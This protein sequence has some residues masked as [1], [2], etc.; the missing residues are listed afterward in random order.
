ML[1]L[2]RTRRHVLAG[3]GRVGPPPSHGA[4][5]ARRSLPVAHPEAAIS[6]RRPHRGRRRPAVTQTGNGTQSCAA[7]HRRLITFERAAA[8]P[9]SWRRCR[10]L[11]ELGVAERSHHREKTA[12]RPDDQG[13]ADRARVHQHALR[14]HEDAG[15]DD[16]A[17]DDGDAVHHA[18]LLLHLDTTLVAHHR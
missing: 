13:E 4:A 12:Q 11:T 7:R 6:C 18:Q 15:A 9:A 17:D 2:R 14:R 8:G 1:R 10:A 3:P 16:N 5:R